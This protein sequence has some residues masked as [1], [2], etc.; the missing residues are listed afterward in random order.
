MQLYTPIV[1]IC[2][3][4]AGFP[5]TQNRT[6]QPGGAQFVDRGS[7][8]LCYVSAWRALKS[9]VSPRSCCISSISP[10]DMR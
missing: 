1:Q 10:L 5:D 6:P 7:V 9:A 3:K 2:E 8:C 4:C